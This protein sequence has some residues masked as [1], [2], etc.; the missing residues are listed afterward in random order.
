MQSVDKRCRQHKGNIDVGENRVSRI[1]FICGVR[2]RTGTNFL[3]QL[4]TKHPRCA[5]PG[6]IEDFFL[7]HSHLLESFADRAYLV[8]NENLE[9]EGNKAK[10]EVLRSMG[11]G[12]EGF[13]LEQSER[14]GSISDSSQIIVTKTPSAEA[15][16][17][18]PQM[19][20]DSRV[21]ILVR[22]GRAVVESA[23]KTWA[24]GVDF[25]AEASGWAKSVRGGPQAS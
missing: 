23:M 11:R 20:P 2:R 4:L 13:L 9:A 10:A 1:C 25:D 7:H 8:W 24:R 3:Y 16:E 5:H 12:L 15:V 6:E 21:I 17:R 22:D 14:Y 19:F 18:M